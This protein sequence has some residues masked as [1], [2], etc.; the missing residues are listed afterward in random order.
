[1]TLLLRRYELLD[2]RLLGGRLYLGSTLWAGVHFGGGLLL[3]WLDSYVSRGGV[4]PRWLL[5]TLAGICLAIL[6]RRAA[7]GPALAAATV[8][9]AADA[10]LGPSAGVLIAYGDA[11]YA[12]C[13]WGRRRLTYGTLAAVV[14]GAAAVLVL[15]LYALRAGY[16]PGAL[17]VLQELGL[18]ILVFVTPVITGLSVREHHLRAE[19]ERERTRQIVRMAE[20]DRGTAIAEERGRMARELHDVIA[21]HLSA[22]AVQSTAALSMRDPDPERV[23]QVLGVVRDNSVQGL[24]EMRRMIGVLRADDNPD[25]ERVMPRLSEV[26]RLMHTAREA[27]LEVRMAQRGTPRPLPVQADAAAYRIVQEC[28]TNALRYAVPR[29]VE[30][31]LSYAEQ[32]RRSWL[33]ITAENGVEEQQGRPEQAW[34]PGLGGGAGLTGMRERAV[35]LGGRFDAGAVDGQG[36]RL[37]RV[38]VE[39]PISEEERAAD[40]DKERR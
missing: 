16:L 10:L 21:N 18:Y 13:V 28:L 22:I 23:R 9:L 31:T 5:L 24:A 25:L 35:L 2:R 39:L 8:V 4:D 29:R 19:L 34:Y 26:D 15:L 37:W 11:L 38:C 32:D 6:L 1:M 7:P 36:R 27:G 17:S 20:L 30:I 3:W 14:A 12:A 40:M 33:V